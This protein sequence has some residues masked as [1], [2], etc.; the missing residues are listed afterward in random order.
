M[1][2]LGRNSS[3]SNSSPGA[4]RRTSA[5]SRGSRGVRRRSSEAYS[6][7]TGTV[8]SVSEV[9]DGDVPA[10]RSAE[11]TQSLP[12]LLEVRAAPDASCPPRIAQPCP[13]IHRLGL[14]PIHSLSTSDV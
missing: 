1:Q 3:P 2:G 13:Q 8:D 7:S 11:H 12:P 9:G 10:R 4:S 5:G 14:T 6:A